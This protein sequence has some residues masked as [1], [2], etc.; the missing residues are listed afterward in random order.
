[1]Q[2][3]NQILT[4]RKFIIPKNQRGFNWKS[5]HLNDYLQDLEIVGRGSAHYVGPMIVTKKGEGFTAGDGTW[6]QEFYL[7]DGQQRVTTFLLLAN[8]IINKLRDEGVNEKKFSL[9]EKCIFYW[10]DANFEIKVCRLTNENADLNLHIK[11]LFLDGPPAPSSPAVEAL[12]NMREEIRRHIATFDEEA[13]IS[14]LGQIFN[15]S[16]AVN[17]DLDENRI[18]RYLAFDA[19]NSRGL[20]LSEYDKIKNFCILVFSQTEP[21]IEIDINKLW[22]ESLQNLQKYNSSDRGNENAYIT[23]LFHAYHSDENRRISSEIHQSLVSDYRKLLTDSDQ[24]LLGGL[25]EFVEIWVDYSESFGFINFPDRVYQS[26]CSRKSKA[27]LTCI[28]NMNMSGIFRTLLSV[29]HYKFTKL[30]FEKVVDAC[31]IFLFRVY[32]LG[33]SR[34]DNRKNDFIRLAHE[35]LMKDMTAVVLIEKL[36]EWL[37]FDCS[38]EQL[39][40]TLASGDAKYAND[41]DVKGWSRGCYYFLYEYDRGH[42]GSSGT[43]PIDW[44]TEDGIKVETQEHILPQTHRDRGWWEEHWPNELHA[45]KFKHRLGNLVLTKDRRSNASLGCSPFP[46]KLNGETGR[47]HYYNHDQHATC[48]EKLIRNYS[49]GE[50]WQR[51]EILKRE[52]DMIKWAVKRWQIDGEESP[53]SVILGSDFWSGMT[54]EEREEAGLTE[55]IDLT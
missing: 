52:V 31:E 30:E 27:I 47:L 35:V 41:P 7:D 38:L 53:P 4:T 24:E 34:V 3:L 11:H 44:A 19:I 50:T 54:R 48:T 10:D 5:K 17:I 2:Q 15:S 42:F 26:Q 36:R 1:M 37:Q 49:D 8:E 14:L 55:E 21:P 51:V 28:D 43:Y 29:C 23:S 22:Y 46:I 16:L 13:L 12:N 45:E 39:V 18:N 20:P 6:V 32:V 25:K 40:H 33:G 9:H